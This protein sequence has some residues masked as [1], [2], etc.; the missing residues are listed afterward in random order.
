M[1]GPAAAEADFVGV[2]IGGRATC[3]FFTAHKPSQFFFVDL[4]SGLCCGVSRR[5]DRRRG[6][7]VRVT[8]C[9][10]VIGP[11]NLAQGGDEESA[12]VLVVG[13]AAQTPL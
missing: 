12:G 7:G 6:V 13:H 8:G 2:S 1:A 10:L 4:F 5:T 11:R 3:S 9:R